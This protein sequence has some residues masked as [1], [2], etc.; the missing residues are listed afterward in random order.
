M[1][2]RCLHGR[3]HDLG[4]RTEEQAVGID[5]DEMRGDVRVL[6]ERHPRRRVQHGHDG[7]ALDRTVDKTGGEDAR[8]HRA[9][10]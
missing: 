4:Y 5:H 7:V 2:I 6:H 1:P 3:Q 10:Y 9:G 8:D